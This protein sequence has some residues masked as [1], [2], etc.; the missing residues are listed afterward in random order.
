[1]TEHKLLTSQKNQVFEIIERADLNPADFDW[2]KIK[3]H[4]CIN[5][6]EVICLFSKLVLKS[7]PQ[8]FFLFEMYEDGHCYTCSPGNE[9]FEEEECPDIWEEQLVAV[10]LW[11]S[12]L[13]DEID[14]PDLWS[15]LNKYQIA[16]S[17]DV[18]DDGLNEVI[19][20]S[21]AEIISDKLEFLGDEIKKVYN[22][23]SE[24]DRF[25]RTKLKYLAEAAKRSRTQDWAAIALTVFQTIMCGLTLTPEQQQQLLGIIKSTFSFMNLIG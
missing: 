20:A 21:E 22:L 3:C 14:A 4:R 2:S 7:H 17:P 6:E 19:S 25:V 9:L 15:D 24:Q 10:E 23:V 18:A 5:D 8:Y 13:K 12:N 16:I 11:V 1:M